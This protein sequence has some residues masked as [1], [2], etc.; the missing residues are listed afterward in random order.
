MKK[1]EIYQELS[2]YYDNYQITELILKETD[3]TKNQLFLSEE[4]EII[5]QKWLEKQ[6]PLAE[7]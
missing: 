4:I 1:Q 3:F 6:I 2:K 5:N 7:N